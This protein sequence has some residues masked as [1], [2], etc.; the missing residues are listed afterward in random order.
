MSR[1]YVSAL[2]VLKVVERETLQQ[3]A[4]LKS[5]FSSSLEYRPSSL[6]VIPVFFLLHSMRWKVLRKVSGARGVSGCYM[7]VLKR[8]VE[9][10]GGYFC[11]RP[12]E[13]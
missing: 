11:R 13:K 6:M 8:S 1:T 10:P 3:F 2:S 4:Y 7:L 9:D 12:F 5:L